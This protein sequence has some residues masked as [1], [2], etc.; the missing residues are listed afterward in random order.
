[1]TLK[2]QE[3][4]I[5]ADSRTQARTDLGRWIQRLLT[6]R[7]K[8]RLGL[9][10]A[11]QKQAELAAARNS[12]GLA[13]AGRSRAANLD[14]L[15]VCIGRTRLS[16]DEQR[17][18]ELLLEGAKGRTAGT[19]GTAFANVSRLYD[20]DRV[21][22][23]FVRLCE[24]V[25][26]E[27]SQPPTAL[28]RVPSQ[29]YVDQSVSAG[30]TKRWNDFVIDRADYALAFYHGID[31]WIS[32]PWERHGVV[33]PQVLECG[34]L[35]GTGFNVDQ[36]VFRS[37]ATSFVLDQRIR[38]MTT[39]TFSTWHSDVLAHNGKWF[40]SSLLRLE[41]VDS[42]GQA[43]I[44]STEA[45]SYEDVCRT[46]MILD[47]KIPGEERTL[48]QE[49]HPNGALK[50]LQDSQLANVLG[51]DTVLFT[52]DGYAALQVRSA[53]VAVRPGQLGPTFS[54]DFDELDAV[55]S[56]SGPLHASRLFREAGEE[57]R[58]KA[59]DVAGPLRFLG[60]TREMV[61]GG[62]PQIHCAG[63]S[64]LDRQDVVEQHKTAKDSWEADDWEFIYIGFAATS[65]DPL[66][67]HETDDLMRNL[68]EAFG[69]AKH[70]TSIP[71]VTNLALW[72]AHRTSAQW[73]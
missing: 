60:I 13:T 20:K 6:G 15:R 57:A 66:S 68:G 10:L 72:A 71:A 50:A 28:E 54:G 69:S 7:P 5:S 65:D 63:R 14:L 59:T 51:I 61:R 25:A 42:D 52:R 62:K 1:M 56:I 18:V 22:R 16:A 27:L 46:H 40:D 73:Q 24:L 29:C 47:A 38:D 64:D 45:V 41:R 36:L 12:P 11:D 17:I 70:R 49:F 19:I 43:Y 53:K 44:L 4:A 55:T 67:Q 21:H 35:L 32:V 48:R 30:Q 23:E 3:V 58:I 37:P 8:A 9:S 26:A 31:S 39:E 2:S 33:V 34:P